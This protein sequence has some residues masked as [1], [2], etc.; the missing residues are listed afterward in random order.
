MLHFIHVLLMQ[1]ISFFFFFFFFLN[2]SIF[3]KHSEKNPLFGFIFYFLS[4]V[5][6]KTHIL[7]IS[8]YNR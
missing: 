7:F 6:A 3:T 5:D 8:Q 4:A 1:L 2:A